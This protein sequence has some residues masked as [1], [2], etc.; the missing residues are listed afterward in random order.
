AVYVFGTAG[1]FALIEYCT[2]E[3]ESDDMRDLQGLAWRRPSSAVAMT[4][5][6]LSL[7]GIPLTG[8]VIGKYYLF[9]TTIDAGYLGLAFVGILASIAGAYYYLRVVVVMYMKDTRADAAPMQAEAWGVKF[10]LSIS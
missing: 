2:D 8:G 6:M 3:R 7:A 4:I 10:A 1:A 9:K 5:F